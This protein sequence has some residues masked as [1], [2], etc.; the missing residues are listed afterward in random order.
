MHFS[1]FVDDRG[2]AALQ[3]GSHPEYAFMWMVLEIHV[4]SLKVSHYKTLVWSHLID[5]N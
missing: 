3:C 1:P 5:A 2:C 4:R